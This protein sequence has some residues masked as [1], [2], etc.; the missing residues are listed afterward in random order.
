[1]QEGLAVE[2]QSL[3]REINY[4]LA[5]TDRINTRTLN[6]NKKLLPPTPKDS[7]EKIKVGKLLKGWLQ[8]T[9]EVIRYI[10]YS[11]EEIERRLIRLGK[12]VEVGK[13]KKVD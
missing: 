4:L 1:M 7:S 11:L 10:N 9:S 8:Q 12:G 2:R 6:I 5:L 13:V 3:I